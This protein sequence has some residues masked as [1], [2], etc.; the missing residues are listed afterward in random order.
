MAHMLLYAVR[1]VSHE[2]GIFPFVSQT[3]GFV[4]DCNEKNTT[5]MGDQITVTSLLTNTSDT[6]ALK[7]SVPVACLHTALHHQLSC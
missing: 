1:G 4:C 3:R 7:H 5:E 6:W 2:A